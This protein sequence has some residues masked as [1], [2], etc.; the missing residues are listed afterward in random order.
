MFRDFLLNIGADYF[1]VTYFQ[2]FNKTIKLNLGC[3]LSIHSS[4]NSIFAPIVSFA[5][6]LN[7]DQP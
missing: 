5:L 2:S 6:S 1:W 7:I 3:P 4:W